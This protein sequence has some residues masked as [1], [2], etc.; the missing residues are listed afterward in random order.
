[1][2]THK[3]WGQSRTEDSGMGN[4]IRIGNIYG[5]FG[6]GY[7]GN[8]YLA[9]G[10]CPTIKCESGGGGRVPMVIIWTSK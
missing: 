10:L 6:S 7:A 8:V 5:D 3:W 4:I 2:H 1:M 9:E